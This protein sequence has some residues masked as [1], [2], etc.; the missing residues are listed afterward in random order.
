MKPLRRGKFR[1]RVAW[2]EPITSQAANGEELVTWTE[3]FKT[4]S[5]IEPLS[6]RERL[7]GNQPIAEGSTRICIFW[8]TQAERIN[9]KWR[10]RHRDVI[11]NI[12]GPPAEIEMA[13]RELEI[14]ATSGV[15]AG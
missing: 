11:Y 6:G 14:I 1:H 12:A 7:T 5:L 3:A 2:D 4:W 8:S 15:N 9:A 10:A 13:H